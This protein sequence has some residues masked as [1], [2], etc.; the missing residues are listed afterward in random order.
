[1]V[2]ATTASAAYYE[3]SGRFWRMTQAPATALKGWLNIGL[4]LTLLGLVAVIL[5]SAA[6]RL[7]Q[8]VRAGRQEV[9]GTDA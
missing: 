8:A 5:V 3:V 7:F 1:M 6:T 4:T 2:A 9:A